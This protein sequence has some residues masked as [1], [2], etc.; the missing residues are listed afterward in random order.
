[1]RNKKAA[2]IVL[3]AAMA[4]SLAACGSSDSASS[5]AS[6]SSSS[7]SSSASS[8]SASTS[9]ASEAVSSGSGSSSSS[10]FA[11]I[12]DSYEPKGTY[13]IS[14]IAKVTDEHF[15]KVEAGAQ[16]YCDEHPNITIDISSPTSATAYDEQNN[17]I[18]TAFS[19]DTYDGYVVAPLSSD[20]MA[21]LSANLKKPLIAVDTDFNADA[22]LAFVGTGNEAAAKSGGEAAIKAAK[23]AGVDPTFVILTGVQGDPTH[24]ARMNGFKEGAEGAGGQFLETQYCDAIAD[25]ASTAMEAIIQKYPDGVGCVLCTNDDMCAA[26][27]RIARESGNEAYTK[28]IFCGFDGNQATVE[29][30]QSG[31]VSMDV[32]QMGYNMGYMAVE[33]CVKALDGQQIDKNIDSGSEII[34]SSNAADYIQYLKDI[35][36]Y[37]VS[38]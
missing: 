20:S 32:A 27:A 34:D 37:N 15:A 36:C 11:S 8:E 10:G 29:G 13:K 3:T 30:I 21:T 2:A 9:S 25:R 26:A 17:A 19:N 6:G 31:Q 14:M 22:K 28:T 16:A 4:L 33:A 5:Q 24:D 23:E 7:A 18:E 38:K 35:G 12:T 1:M